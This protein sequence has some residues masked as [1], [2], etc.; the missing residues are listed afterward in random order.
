MQ[1]ILMIGMGRF[2][3]HLCRNLLKYDNEIMIVD[4]DEKA[5][6]DIYQQVSS[7]KIGDCTN[8][9]VLK[10]LGIDNFDIIFIC[11]GTDFQSSLEVTDLVSEMGGRRIISRA[12]RDIQEK[13]LLKNGAHEV[14]FP[15]KVAAE[16]LARSAS[17]DRIFDYIELNDSHGIY[18]IAP[19]KGWIGKSIIELN[20]RSK[21]QGIIIGTKNLATKQ[22]NLMPSPDYVF[23]NEENLLVLS[24]EKEIQKLLNNR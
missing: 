12:T 7:S 4:K 16:N 23:N 17:D 19:L 18:E 5:I 15:D 1:S 9:E 11:I 3:H 13:F 21:Y 10:T 6:Q 14:I 24:A 8:P 22:K 2:G 20:F